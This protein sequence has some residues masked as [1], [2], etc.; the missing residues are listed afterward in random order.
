MEFVR[1][2]LGQNGKVNNRIKSARRRASVCGWSNE[3]KIQAFYSEAAR[4]TTE[5]GIKHVVDHIVPLKNK[6]VCGLHN[7]FNLRAITQ[8]ENA[9]KK[10]KFE[11]V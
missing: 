10:N 5:T 1:Y 6:H 8:R 3:E 7:E 4:L 2:H 9:M 11:V